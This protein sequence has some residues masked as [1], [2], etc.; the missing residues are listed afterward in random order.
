M[1]TYY[2]PRNVKGEGKILFIFSV[3][4]LIYSCI[5][6]TVGLIFYFIFSLLNL[7]LVG[8]IIVILFAAIGFT[9][10]TFKVPNI[11]SLPFTETIA[12]EKIDDIL[13]RTF[14]FKQKK[15]KLY[16]YSM[17]EEEND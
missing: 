3:K 10:G 13:L 5:C 7:H 15:D 14:K 16:I 6:A 17:E 9:I 4:A 1:G 8:I 11:P 2:M 12:G